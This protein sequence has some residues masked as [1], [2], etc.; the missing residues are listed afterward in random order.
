ALRADNDLDLR[1]GCL[2][3]RRLCMRPRR[4]EQHT[5]G[6][7]PS[8]PAIRHRSP[9]NAVAT[10]QAAADYVRRVLGTGRMSA[11]RPVGSALAGGAVNAHKGA[12]ATDVSGGVECSIDPAQQA[13]LPRTQ[14]A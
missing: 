13:P 12:D 7:E 10:E 1:C 9:P 11:R 2:C 8:Q 4:T 3:R 14:N 5:L 6:T